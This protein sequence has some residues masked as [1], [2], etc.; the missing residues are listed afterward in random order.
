MPR[1]RQRRVVLTL[2][3]AAPQDVLE[4]D[5]ARVVTDGISGIHLLEVSGAAEKNTYVMVR[6]T[7][8]RDAPVVLQHI[9]VGSLGE[10]NSVLADWGS[11]LDARI[12]VLQV[13]S[14]G[15]ITTL[16]LRRQLIVV[17]PEA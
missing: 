1:Q 8:M 14:S 7:V 6:A 13:S 17:G 15:K 2:A 4:S 10:V 3:S 9:Q 12:E 5:I 11:D 16:E